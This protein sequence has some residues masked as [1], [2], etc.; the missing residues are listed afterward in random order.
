MSAL[1]SL[2]RAIDRLNE[3]IGNAQGDQIHVAILPFGHPDNFS[4]E[5]YLLSNG[6]YNDSAVDIDTF[7]WNNRDFLVVM[8]VGNNGGTVGNNRLGLAIQ[9][10]AA[11]SLTNCSANGSQLRFRPSLLEMF[12]R[13][14]SAL[15]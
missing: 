1:I 10:F 9:S 7:A 13:W 8:P 3:V 12:A 2:V 15:E 4:N 6:T 11:S 14:H 5:Q